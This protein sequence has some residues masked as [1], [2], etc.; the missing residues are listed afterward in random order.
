MTGIEQTLALSR[1]TIEEA[2]GGNPVRLAAAIHAQVGKQGHTMG[3][4]PVEAIAAALDIIEIRKE[5]T[6][7]LEGALVTT[8]ERSV[9]SILVN[10]A[11]NHRRQ[12][13]TIAH[14]LGHYLNLW[15]TPT[16]GDGFACTKADLRQAGSASKPG[17]TRHQVQERQANR[18]AAELLM[19]VSRMRPFLDRGPDIDAVLDLVDTLDCSRETM[20]RR[21]AEQHEAAIAIVFSHKGR[22]RYGISS[23]I[24]PRIG[25]RTGDPMPVLPTPQ[26]G[27][28]I[29]APIEADADDWINAKPSGASLTMQ[30]LHQASGFAMTLLHLESDDPDEAHDME[31]AFERY[32]RFDRR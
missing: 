9:G 18:F 2:G 10:S 19:P 6:E 14:E 30:T 11:S 22:C 20:A 5:A 12:R 29:S 21:Y 26:P 15:H 17:L 16:S 4:V 23:A 32:T 24:F 27:E 28:A 1:M 31:D 3:P 7:N 25:L 8:A 13:F